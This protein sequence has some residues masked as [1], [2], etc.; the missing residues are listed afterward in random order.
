M[1]ISNV[2]VFNAQYS[3]KFVFHCGP[4]SCAALTNSFVSF[5]ERPIC[6]LVALSETVPV[7]KVFDKM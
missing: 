2:V 3:Q 5:F 4:E 7:L 1:F 6:A